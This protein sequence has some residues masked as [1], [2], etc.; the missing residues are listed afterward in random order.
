MRP[1]EDKPVRYSATYRHVN[2][3]TRERCTARRQQHIIQEQHLPRRCVVYLAHIE[4]GRVADTHD[5]E[6]TTS[7]TLNRFFIGLRDTPKGKKG[8]SLLISNNNPIL[9][10]HLGN[11]SSSKTED[12]ASTSESPKTSAPLEKLDLNP[13]ALPLDKQPLEP[14]KRQASRRWSIQQTTRERTPS[15]DAQ[16]MVRRPPRALFLLESKS[17]PGVIL[18][19]HMDRN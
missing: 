18:G 11:R 2:G 5:L 12:M 8:S 16:L 13:S 14:A 4:C 3:K 6:N 1:Q 10:E 17:K 19:W 15:N 9:S 7:S